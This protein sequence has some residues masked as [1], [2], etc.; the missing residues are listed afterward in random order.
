[1]NFEHTES[2]ISKIYRDLFDEE[3]SKTHL[4]DELK[5]F[6]PVIDERAPGGTEILL[7]A[8]LE[9]RLFGLYSV[10]NS[11][12]QGNVRSFLSPDDALSIL[13]NFSDKGYPQ[14]QFLYAKGLEKQKNIS[15]ECRAELMVRSYGKILEN[16]YATTELR[17]KTSAAMVKWMSALPRPVRGA[18]FNS[19]ARYA[20]S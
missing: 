8:Q 10:A 15:E 3:I 11:V 5:I 12:L 14:A 18:I 9:D 4:M 13:K 7:M 19:F 20:R 6:P 1:M 16:P 17:Y 2:R